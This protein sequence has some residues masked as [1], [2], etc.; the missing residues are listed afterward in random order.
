MHL[1]FR[2]RHGIQSSYLMLLLFVNSGFRVK[3]GMTIA[4]ACFVECCMSC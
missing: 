2:A 3:H 4:T 1:S